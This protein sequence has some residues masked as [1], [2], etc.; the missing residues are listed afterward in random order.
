MH[1]ATGFAVTWAVTGQLLGHVLVD[2]PRHRWLVAA[3]AVCIGLALGV[4]W[5]WAEWAIDALSGRSDLLKGLSDTLSDLLMD[6]IGAA[7]AGVLLALRVSR[8]RSA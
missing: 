3:L 8:I 4:L 2:D 5:E 7:A 6:G 1:L